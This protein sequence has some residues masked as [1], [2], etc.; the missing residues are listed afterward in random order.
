[1]VPRSSSS[2]SLATN[3]DASL[4]GTAENGTECEGTAWRAGEGSRANDGVVGVA[5]EERTRSNGTRGTA[6]GLA[7]G[8]RT[9]IGAA[10]CAAASRSE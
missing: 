5:V 2:V 7:T 4:R 3:D 9:N 6:G 8:R 10:A 1:M